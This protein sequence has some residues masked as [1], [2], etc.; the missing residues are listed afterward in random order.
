M[1]RPTSHLKWAMLAIVLAVCGCTETAEN[2]QSSSET[3]VESDTESV[4][5]G[6]EAGT[7]ALVSRK[8]VVIDPKTHPGRTLFEENCLTCHN[9]NV[10]KAPAAVW[11]EMMSPD[12]LLA[13]MNEGIMQEQ[14][15][16]L[17]D[18]QRTLIA[19]YIS[20]TS[21]ADYTPPAPPAMCEGEAKAF[22]GWPPARLGWGHDTR[23]FIPADV[24]GITPEAVPG[25]TLKW[26][27]AYPGALRARS[28]PAIGWNTIF[29]GSQDGHVYAFDIDS[30]CTKWTWRAPAEVRTA[31]VV[32]PDTERLYFGDV[33]ARVYALNAKTGDVLWQTRVDEHANA[34]VTGTPSLG[35]GQL[36]VPVSSLEVVTA[37]NPA[38]ACCTFAGSV[39]GLDLET[40]EIQWKTYTVSEQPKK[41]GETS[42]G[43]AVIAPSGAPVWNSPAWDKERGRIYYGSGENY[44]SP[45]DGN[46]DAIFAVDAKT[47]EKIWTTQ[48]TPRDAWN[49]A[50]VPIIRNENCPEEDGP[51][52]DFAASPIIAADGRTLVIGQKS[53]DVYGLNIETGEILWNQRLGRGGTSGGVHFGMASDGRTVW[54]PINDM[55]NTGG[56][57]I[58]LYGAGL[59][60]VDI[61]TGDVLWRNIVE[62]DFCEGK[63]FCDPGISSAITAIPGIVFAGHLD[64]RLKAY[65]SATGEV[66]WTWDTTQNVETI[67]GTVAHGGSMSGPG[68]AVADGHLVLN[69]GYGLYNHMPG[70]L[71]MVFSAAPSPE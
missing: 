31:I 67:T 63:D 4:V 62:N 18:E 64:G 20:R 34:T 52:Y 1:I 53:G 69:S 30:G 55:D 22:A 41:V 61:A 58:S 54:V 5:V 47:G 27:Y 7:E 15:A 65:D 49:M 68:P 66:V 16:H 37:A 32:D 10:A 25:L 11:L 8:G 6:H 46:S 35:D 36:F 50:C 45:A 19:E 28:Q 40:G 71:L 43:T 60:A 48:L 12:L 33:H 56:D 57:D 70:N 44:S 13:A 17:S 3:P 14:S 42:I 26:A 29:V 23:R 59:H 51:D 2:D 24:A 21:L 39:V 38:Y 9:G